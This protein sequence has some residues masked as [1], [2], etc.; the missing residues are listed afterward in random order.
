M[1]TDRLSWK[2]MYVCLGSR[3]VLCCVSFGG[4]GSTLEL[5]L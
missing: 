5:W 4:E 1:K 3:E 2:E